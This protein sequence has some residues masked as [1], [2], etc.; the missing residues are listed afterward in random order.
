LDFVA[1]LEEVSGK[2]EKKVVPTKENTGEKRKKE[3]T[4][5]FF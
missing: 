4:S 1:G 2:G 5:F 3:K